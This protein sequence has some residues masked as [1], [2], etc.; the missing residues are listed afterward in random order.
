MFFFSLSLSLSLFPFV[1]LYQNRPDGKIA[2]LAIDNCVADDTAEPV[3]ITFQKA[4]DASIRPVLEADRFVDIE[5]NNAPT[6]NR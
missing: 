1:C 3:G 6:K 2:C 5:W 4:T